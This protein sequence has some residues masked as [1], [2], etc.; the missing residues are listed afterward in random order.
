MKYEGV[1]QRRE[2]LRAERIARNWSQRDVA[3]HLGVTVVTISR[4]ER[5]IHAPGPYFRLRLCTLFNKDVVALGLLSSDLINTYNVLQD[6]R[7]FLCDSIIPS[8][9]AEQPPLV[10]RVDALR[11]IVAQFC[12]LRKTVYAVVGIPG[13][14]KTSLAVAL[15]YHPH[16]RQHFPDGVLW[17]GLGSACQ[18][19]ETLGRW[20]ILLGLDLSEFHALKTVEDR[21]RYIYK[22]LDDRRMLIILDDAWDLADAALF[23][24]GGNRCSYLLTT[25]FPVLAHSFAREQVM[26]LHE[27][28]EED[29]LALLQRIAPFVYQ[30]HAE[31]LQRLVKAVG[32]LP[33]ALALL[34]QHLHVRSLSGPP[35]RL[36]LEVQQLCRSSQERFSV[37]EPLASWKYAPGSF[38]RQ[39]MSLRIAIDLSVNRLS[40]SVQVALCS[41]AIFLPEPYNFS[42]E[43]ALTGGHL[44]IEA[45]DL[46]VDNGLV[47]FTSTGFYQ[48]HQ[49]IVDYARLQATKEPRLLSM[50]SDFNHID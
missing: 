39:A 27:L 20:S 22:C 15:A 42:E 34:G 19:N 45:L 14:G 17:A 24:I 48:I 8:P 33:L 30:R 3:E 9:E 6:N 2:A 38:T 23:Q 10:G 7:L 43:M 50:L 41:L 13:V 36:A 46:L 29:S 40:P 49:T 25:R 28:T 21:A 26:R 16:I 32:G 35:R 12:T 31:D 4:W 18:M 11:Q 5:G 1:S 47:E 37:E 44:S